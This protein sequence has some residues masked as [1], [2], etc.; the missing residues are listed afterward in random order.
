MVCGNQIGL[1]PFNEK[2]KNSYNLMRNIMD[3]IFA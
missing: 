1:D 2:P 3:N